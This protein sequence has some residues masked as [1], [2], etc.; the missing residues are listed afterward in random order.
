MKVAGYLC[1]AE[2]LWYAS[3]SDHDDHEQT[4]QK[5]GETKFDVIICWIDE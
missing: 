4:N 2:V 1:G 5:R 3:F